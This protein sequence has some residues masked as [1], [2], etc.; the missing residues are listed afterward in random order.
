MPE[1]KTLERAKK[2]LR[3]GKSASTA[4][5]EFVKEE[6]RHV[7]TAK[8]GARS[9]KQ[10]IAIGLSKAR[11]AGIPLPP[12]PGATAAEKA[13]AKKRRGPAKKKTAAQKRA[14]KNRAAGALKR[15]KR[16]PTNTASHAA[17][18]AHAK[19]VARR[20]TKAQRSRSAKKAAATRKKSAAKG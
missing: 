14:S 6:I 12:R 7:R 2:D 17:L 8:H 19:S 3:E 1:K 13:A 18:S 5:G 4:A 10:A 11:R 16:H 15:L 9:A 20:R